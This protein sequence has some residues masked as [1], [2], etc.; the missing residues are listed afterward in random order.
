ME[1]WEGFPPE[2][3]DLVLGPR[4]RLHGGAGSCVL[5]ILQQQRNNELFPG[6]KSSLTVLRIRDVYPEYPG[7]DFSN[8][9]PGSI[10]YGAVSTDEDFKESCY[11]Y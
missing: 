10:R 1:T 4:H 9:S 5:D 8:P 6:R 11:C 3:L 7:S 2:F